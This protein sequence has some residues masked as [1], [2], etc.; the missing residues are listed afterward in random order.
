MEISFVQANGY[1]ISHARLT[2]L[3]VTILVPII[4]RLVLVAGRARRGHIGVIRGAVLWG[5]VVSAG[6]GMPARRRV[7]RARCASAVQGMQ[8]VEMSGWTAL[9]AA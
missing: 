7:T 1:N 5:L 3:L 8:R 4:V 9:Q 2:L 6:S